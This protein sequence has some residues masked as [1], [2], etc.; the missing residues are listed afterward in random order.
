ML[1][2][3]RISLNPFPLEGGRTTDPLPLHSFHYGLEFLL[4]FWV[5]RAKPP[6]KHCGRVKFKIYSN[7]Y[8]LLTHL[9]QV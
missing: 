4:D 8:S 9:S 1:M 2:L 6:E 7:D 5:L 3:R